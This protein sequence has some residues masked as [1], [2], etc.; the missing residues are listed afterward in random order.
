MSIVKA[1]AIV[2]ISF[3]VGILAHAAE[4]QCPVT[5]QQFLDGLSKMK[6][7]SS[8]YVVFKQ[9]IPKCP[10]DGFY[11]EGYTEVVVVALARKWD[12]LTQ[13]A[14]LM[15]KD[16]AFRKFVY[17]HISGSADLSD[18]RQVLR[19]A[20]G[21]CPVDAKPLCAEIAKRTRVA[22]KEAG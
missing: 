13:L 8:I 16:P 22:V 9:N 7:W 6:D 18:L 10:D 4:V 15:E 21:R 17:R 20:E 5:D 3:R 2:A 14:G 19:N 12:D 1:A 11:A